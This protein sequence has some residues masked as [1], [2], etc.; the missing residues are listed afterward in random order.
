MRSTQIPYDIVASWHANAIFLPLGEKS[1][2]IDHSGSRVIAR[3]SPPD[4]SAMKISRLSI[5]SLS[6]LYAIRLP[7]GETAGVSM[8]DTPSTSRSVATGVIRRPLL[9]IEYNAV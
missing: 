2:S 5:G 3:G 7:S 4:A 9:A 6:R 8:L 1:G